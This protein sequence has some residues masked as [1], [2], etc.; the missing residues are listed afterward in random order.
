MI[1]K[2]FIENK[3]IA[4]PWKGSQFVETDVVREN[5]NDK[6]IALIRELAQKKAKFPSV[7]FNSN[8]FD[9]F[10]PEVDSISTR[11][12]SVPIDFSTESGRS[13][14]LKEIERILNSCKL[15]EEQIREL[16]SL[17]FRY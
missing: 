13:A 12:H 15:R 16:M 14:M 6:N 8:I 11:Y 7:Q 1:N 2:S 17:R 4:L 5:K 3:E 9:E 10:K